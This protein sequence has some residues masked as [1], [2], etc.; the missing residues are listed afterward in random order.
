MMVSIEKCI[1]DGSR[2]GRRNGLEE[3]AAKFGYH[4]GRASYGV[5]YGFKSQGQNANK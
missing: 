1:R 2:T 5:I 4:S 3:T